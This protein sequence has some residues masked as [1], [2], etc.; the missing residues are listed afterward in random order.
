MVKQSSLLNEDE[1]LIQLI[2]TYVV[3]NVVLQVL[4]VQNTDSIC[5]INSAI[6]KW[7]RFRSKLS[8]KRT[9]TPKI[10]NLCVHQISVE[11]LNTYVGISQIIPL[12][13]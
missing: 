4:Y 10:F 11:F 13:K 9:S 2:A 6:F 5:T 7:K 3:G 8:F 1:I 12:G